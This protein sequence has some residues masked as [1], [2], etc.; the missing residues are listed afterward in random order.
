[1]KV[2][3][4]LTDASPSKDRHRGAPLATQFLAQTPFALTL[5]LNDD[6]PEATGNRPRFGEQRLG[7]LVPQVWEQYMVHA[8]HD[9]LDFAS[10]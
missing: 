8:V 1:V 9:S 6:T 3:I 5:S 2:V 10:S 7:L 4:L